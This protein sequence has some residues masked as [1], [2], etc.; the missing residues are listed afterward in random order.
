MENKDRKVLYKS[1]NNAVYKKIME[2]L[3]KGTDVKLV[4]KKIYY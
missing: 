4:S 3:R 2:N 1:M